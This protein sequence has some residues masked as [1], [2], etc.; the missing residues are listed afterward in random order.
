MTLAH[1]ALL[2]GHMGIGKT[3]SRI[4][5]KFYWPGIQNDVSRY[6]RSC[7][8][9]QKTL[10]KGKVSQVPLDEM[11][12]IDVP[13]KRVAVDLVGPIHPI[14]ASGKRYILTMVD[15]A[16]RYPEAVALSNIDTI[17]VAEAMLDIYSRVGFP[18]EVLS[19]MGSQFTSDLMKEISRLISVRRLTTTPYHPQC[20]GL[21]EKINGVLKTILRRLCHERPKDWDR[22]LSA[23]LFAYTEVPQESTGFAPFELLYG[24]NV[25]GPMTILKE[26]WTKD[27]DEEE[28]KTSY[29]YIL[30]LKDRIQKTCQLAREELTKSARR[31]KR[32]Y[33]KKTK[34]RTLQV[35]DEVLILLP[36]NSNKLLLQW[37]GPYKVVEKSG[38]YTYKI[39]VKGKVK[40]FHI[41]MLKQYW[42]SDP[43]VKLDTREEEGDINVKNMPNHVTASMIIQE[44]TEEG[45]ITLPMNIQYSSG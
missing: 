13:F 41:N 40:N 1:S 45:D 27:L 15:Y 11:P 26:M 32:Y 12:K 30:E 14:A 16:T 10:P 43:E 35:D 33:D 3:V 4:T 34:S 2:G 7:D 18:S 8:I 44:E 22:Y 36:T 23:V 25:R 6:C 29:Q 24:R 38:K 9:C 42:S 28:V 19:D 31:Y 17:T 20:I 37:K 39:K 21:C 5:S